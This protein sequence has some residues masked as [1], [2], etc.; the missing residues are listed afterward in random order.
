MKTTDKKT[1]NPE[2]KLVRL[3]TK[4]TS[5]NTRTR[6]LSELQAE[7]DAKL[8]QELLVR[9]SQYEATRRVELGL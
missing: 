9:A 2:T 1:S 3:E 8:E 4:V 6:T 5:S 7:V